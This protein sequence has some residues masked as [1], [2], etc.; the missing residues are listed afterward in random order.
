M[1]NKHTTTRKRKEPFNELD[2]NKKTRF[3]YSMAQDNSINLI[4]RYLSE[5]RSARQF[6]P[7]KKTCWIV[8]LSPEN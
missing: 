1:K 7:L 2:M 6:C 8:S 5:P 3:F 4:I